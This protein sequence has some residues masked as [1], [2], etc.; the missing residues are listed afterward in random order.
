MNKQLKFLV[1][2]NNK[3]KFDFPFSELLISHK[4]LEIP[5]KDIFFFKERRN[6]KKVAISY[7]ANQNEKK[8][9]DDEN[10][11]E[12]DGDVEFDAKSEVI[13]GEGGDEAEDGEEGEDGDDEGF[14]GKIY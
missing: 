10:K 8:E 7:V 6:P 4:G 3:Y 2:Y 5:D 12:E 13:E 14:E 9:S 1:D 11:E